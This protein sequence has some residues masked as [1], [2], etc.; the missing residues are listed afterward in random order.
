M[1]HG[2]D[3]SSERGSDTVYT[4]TIYSLYALMQNVHGS[5]NCETFRV[6]V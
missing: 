5:A 4:V 6:G 2:L 3:H 1:L